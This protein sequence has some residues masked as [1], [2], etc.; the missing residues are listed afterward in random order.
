[1]KRSRWLCA[2]SLGAFVMTSFPVQPGYCAFIDEAG[3]DGLKESASDWFIL[4]AVVMR[5]SNE[6]LI[7]DWIREI[8]APMKGQQ[9]SELHFQTL[10]PGMRERACEM[11]AGLPIRHFTVVSHKRNMIGYRNPRVERYHG[12]HR[13]FLHPWLLKVLLERVSHFCAGRTLGD[14]GDVRPVRIDIAKRWGFSLQQFKAY[15]TLAKMKS[16]ANRTFLPGDLAWNVVDWRMVRMAPAVAVPGLQIADVVASS[17]H[18]AVD[19]RGRGKCEPH[20]AKI[21]RPRLAVNRQGS[22][23]D[24]GVMVWPR[25]LWRAGLHASQIEIFEACGYSRDWLLSS[26]PRPAD[27]F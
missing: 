7:L 4:S 6:Q 5:A 14:Y 15:L 19:L 11:I 18:A 23:A 17:F 16:T 12:G 22:S 9:R 13:P 10:S 2:F 24:Y 21:L 25:P 8:K 26:G 1:M 3:D 27:R 20:Y